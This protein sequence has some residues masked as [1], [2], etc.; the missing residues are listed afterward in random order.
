MAD[1]HFDHFHLHD[2]WSFKDGAT[3]VE[4]YAGL[5]KERGAKLLAVTNH[6]QAGGFARQ[7][8]VCKKLG[9][10]PVFGMEAYVNEHRLRLQDLQAQLA[11]AKTEKQTDR[12]A[13]LSE[14]IRTVLKPSRH[15]ILIAQ[16]EA[17]FK[18]LVRLSTDAWE[19]GFYGSPRMDTR[20]IAERS[21]GLI[22]STACMG[23]HIPALAR[24]DR[25]AGLREA[26]R[27][28]K[29]FPGRFYVELILTSYKP[30]AET[31]EL[32]LGIATEL[33]LP[34]TI[35]CD[36]HYATPEHNKAQG[37]MLLMRDRKT[38]QDTKGAGE[39]AWQFESKDL[40]YKTKREVV[41][42]W[43]RHHKHYLD[44]ETFLR[45]LAATKALG[46]SIEEWDW[47]L[48]P[49]LPGVFE[50]PARTLREV[51]ALGFRERADR[52]LVPHGSL[53]RDAYLAR[54][55]HELSVIEAKGFSEYFLVLWDL[56]KHAREIGATMGPGRGSAGGSLVAY[57]AGIT[58]V[59]P[60]R[61]NLLFERFL[62][63][64]RTDLPDVDLDVSSQHRE[65][66]KRHLES[67][68]PV[69]ATL[70]TASTFKRKATLN[71]VGR[72]YG[73]PA[74][75]THAATKTMTGTDYDDKPWDVIRDELPLVRK[76]FEDHPEAGE[77]AE[78]LSGLV[79]HRGQH[80]AGVLI[81]PAEAL[82]F[83]PLTRDT[84]TRAANTAYPDTA[85]DGL[86]GVEREISTLGG[87]KLDLLGLANLGTCE[88]ARRIV[89]R[90]TGELIDLDLLPL[91][92]PD[93][94]ALANRGDVPGIFQLDTQVT[95]PI[96]P[97]VGVQ[98][99]EDLV[100]V[101]AL[102][103]PGPLRKGV[104]EEFARLKRTGDAW[105]RNVDPAL[106]GV[107]ARSRGL[108]ILQEDI[109]FTVQVLGGLSMVEAN[110]IR[111]VIGKKQDVA[112]FEPYRLKFVEGGVAQGRPLRVL[113]ETWERILP[114]AEYG[115][116][117]AHSYAYMLTAYRQLWFLAHHATAYFAGSLASV[118]RGTGKETDDPTVALVREAIK[119]G[120][121]V[122]GPSVRF[123]R[124]EW[125]VD[126]R[127]PT[128][129][130]FGLSKVKGIGSAADFLMAAREAGDVE[131]LETLFNAVERRRV[132][133]KVFQTLAYSGALDDLAFEGEEEA[134]AGILRR[135]ALLARYDALRKV[136]EPTAP[137]TPLVLRERE[138]ELLGLP[139][140]WWTGPTPERIRRYRR[141]TTIA[142]T[143]DRERGTIRVLG[144]VT[145]VREIQGSKGPMGFLTIADETGTL[146]NLGVFGAMWKTYRA[147][148]QRGKIN[149]FRLHK[150]EAR[151]PRYGKFAYRLDVDRREES[152]EPVENA[153]ELVRDMDREAAAAS[154]AEE[155][156]LGGGG[157]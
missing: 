74:A 75:E 24:H 35:T 3:S 149:A 55:R 12:A 7:Y 42:C 103:R 31:N 126:D 37:C 80:A 146:D 143:G 85:G 154:E 13:R 148:L 14:A 86:G 48:R 49:K 152:H 30:Q 91:D 108:M 153:N 20:S 72:V 62:D 129:L 144:E 112:A 137:L 88:V 50:N 43:Q 100:M 39:G 28:S 15:T 123:G 157:E 29:V 78:A 99:F 93:A 22:Y 21:E 120:I 5:A 125:D 23:G 117:A 156:R 69:V 142:A 16:N 87:L 84:K 106:Q 104:H 116:N 107:L 121:R 63:P 58:E 44:R 4:T 139:L 136:K 147:R 124:P 150:E 105:K 46:E 113:E 127:D 17:G 66:L 57:L 51:V 65:P 151:N 138:R 36:V 6:G 135:N 2:D 96:L 11:K 26:E 128:A 9:L 34:T 102:A 67:K 27:L 47:D 94:L 40:W 10:K 52:Q 134:P 101:T 68:Y 92:D 8:L 71:D 82:D 133:A 32:M 41:E 70:G 33:G 60:L 155:E 56:C 19:R 77:V 131:S 90:Q 79:S 83:F 119:R 98:A 132:N 81:A 54:V 61:F 109:M 89:E 53:T 140:G 38:I 115:F 18:N 45:S 25:A 76:W 130:R 118:D 1:E 111:K 145:K 114:F 64:T 73:V 110:K 122:L 141:L 97:V 95:R 59:D